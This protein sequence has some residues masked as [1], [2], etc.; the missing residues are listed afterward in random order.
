MTK[1][2]SI[3]ILAALMVLSACTAATPAVDDHTD[4]EMDRDDE[5][6]DAFSSAPY[7]EEEGSTSAED[8]LTISSSSSAATTTSSVATSQPAAGQTRTIAIAVTD[9][10]FTPTT[11]TAKKG[12]KVKL[13]ITGDKGIHGFAIPGLSMNLRIEAGKTVTVDL[14]TDTAGT[15]EAR[16]SIPCGPG[17]RDMKATI[18][19]TE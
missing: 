16:C 14:P 6:S 7:L 3:A 15:F 13:Q 5:H 1:T 19:I 12:E 9:W 11:I 17:H 2:R 8:V 18:I 10:S 4:T